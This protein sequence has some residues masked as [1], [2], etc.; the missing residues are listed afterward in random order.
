MSSDD[1][2]GIGKI[3]VKKVKVH[4]DNIFSKS[5]GSIKNQQSNRKENESTFHIE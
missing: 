4:T 1:E 2:S 5:S 3:P